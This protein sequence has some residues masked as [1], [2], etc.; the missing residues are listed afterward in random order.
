MLINY[1]CEIGI[2]VPRATPLLS[3]VDVHPERRK[4]INTEA[5]FATTPR[6]RR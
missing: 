6:P 2:S 5:P 1:G 4:D 3:L